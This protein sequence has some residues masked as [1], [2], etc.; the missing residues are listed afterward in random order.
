MDWL[1]TPPAVNVMAAPPLI[2]YWPEECAPV[3][4]AYEVLAD[5]TPVQWHSGHPSSL[6]NAWR[7]HRASGGR[8]FLSFHNGKAVKAVH[9]P[10]CCSCVTCRPEYHG[11]GKCMCHWPMP[12]VHAPG[13]CFCSWHADG[14]YP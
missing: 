2:E 3:Y 14:G 8:Y 4:N 13:K 10:D 5:G 12:R 11:P 6:I 7:A 1:L 9:R